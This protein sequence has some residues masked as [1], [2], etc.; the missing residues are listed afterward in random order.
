MGLFSLIGIELS[1]FVRSKFTVIA[2]IIV[3]V[4]PTIYASLYLTANWDSTG[5]MRS[6]RAAV[7]NLD[8]GAIIPNPNDEETPITLGL[9]LVDSLIGAD[10]AGFTWIVA[11]DKERALANLSYGEYSAVLV[12]PED[13]S[14]NVS[15]STSSEPA[16]A[17]L[18]IYTDDASNYL[19]GQI[20]DS[21][22]AT[23][24]TELST[25]VT[26]EFLENVFIGFSEIH[27]GMSTAADGA[28]QLANGTSQIN[29]GAEQLIH[30]I[31][32]LDNG[33]NE[34]TNGL[35]TLYNGSLSLRNG[36]NELKDNAATL[37]NNAQALADG[38]NSAYQ[39]A[40][41]LCN[42]LATLKD[43]TSSLADGTSQ[44]A[45]GLDTIAALVV[46]HPDWT[47]AQLEVALNS[48]GASISGLASTGHTL[49]DGAL[50][51][52][53]GASQTTAGASDL[54]GGLA[55][56]S[57]SLNT[58]AKNA[59]ALSQGIASAAE[60]A[61]KLADG[62]GSAAIASSRLIEGTAR[63]YDG[64]SELKA[65]LNQLSD[66]ST[67]LAEELTFATETV[68]SYTE[69]E[70]QQLATVVSD[71][72]NVEHTTFHAVETFG[73]GIAPFFI[74]L[75][76]WIGGLAL[77]FVFRPF[78][79]RALASTA[80]QH[81]LSASLGTSGKFFALILLIL[82]LT[83]SGGTYPVEVAPKFFQTIAPYLPMI[84]SVDAFAPI[85]R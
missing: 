62:A 11:D 54:S 82:Q 67:T 68:P 49:A 26:S 36:L 40:Q 8:S 44:F 80:V 23:I 59:P 33:A 51:L 16:R 41:N 71:P 15:S 52:C 29:D 55:Q 60:G 46:A 48:Q 50:N 72:V 21:V 39:G 79:S 69:T 9:E 70:S 6:L 42:G 32:E 17:L 57:G 61:S 58:L 37:P 3:M 7:I 18:D 20:T 31:S 5:N 74:S 75:T 4:L 10:D 38:A 22:A 2:V 47:I 78:S 43:G 45:Q 27:D 64:S 24:R 28:T 12:I 53:D 19:I 14:T 56:L 65:G 66:G 34:L 84:Y 25:T 76:L 77:Y 73:R 30:G 83:S 81:L 13:F 85:A 1:R 35:N 63:L